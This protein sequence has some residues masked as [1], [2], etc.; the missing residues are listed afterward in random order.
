LGA[1]QTSAEAAKA[2]AS[3]VQ[4]QAAATILAS[5]ATDRL[6]IAGKAQSDAVLQSL[7]TA[8]EANKIAADAST[9]TNR[10]WVSLQPPA[11]EHELVPGADYQVV[12]SVSNPGRSPATNTQIRAEIRFLP[13]TEKV[14][15]LDACPGCAKITLFPTLGF[16]SGAQVFRPTIPKEQIT[17]D[18][19]A[20]YNSLTEVLLIRARADY[21]DS[22]GAPHH[23]FLCAYYVPKAKGLG[24][25]TSCAA[26]NNA[27]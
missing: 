10:P 12:V 23:T 22:A 21:T 3:A 18:H 27:D 16:D 20:A 11:G 1:I 14:D 15:A 4:K 26:G 17:P 19:V 13:I 5:K 24:G 7:S 6:A 2:Q 25:Y 9:A 8:R